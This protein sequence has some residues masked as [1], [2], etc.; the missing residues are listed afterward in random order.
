MSGN[1]DLR[2]PKKRYRRRRPRCTAKPFGDRCD[3]D[4]QYRLHGDAVSYSV[5]EDCMPRV[6]DDQ[7]GDYDFIELERLL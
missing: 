5:C 6:L 2:G 1:T 7:L 4:A 3:M